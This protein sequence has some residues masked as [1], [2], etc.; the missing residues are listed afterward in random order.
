MDTQVLPSLTPIE[1]AIFKE[2]EKGPTTVE[3]LAQALAERFKREFTPHQVGGYFTNLTPKLLA[4]GYKI[5][6]R[7][8][9]QLSLQL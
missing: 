8:I 4:R 6:H 7:T 2:M 3:G 1:E 9:S 5:Q